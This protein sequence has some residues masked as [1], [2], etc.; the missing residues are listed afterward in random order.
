M[1]PADTAVNARVLQT[2]GFFFADSCTTRIEG[3]DLSDQDVAITLIAAKPTDAILNG[4]YLAT[5][6]PVLAYYRKKGRDDDHNHAVGST[7]INMTLLGVVGSK[8]A[9]ASL[10]ESEQSTIC[11][12]IRGCADGI[13]IICPNYFLIVRSTAPHQAFRD[14]IPTEPTGGW[15][16]VLDAVDQPQAAA[17]RFKAIIGNHRNHAVCL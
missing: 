12:F 13:T 11:N 3:D 1:K 14:L 10:S 6:P 8:R 16:G 4:D 15:E 7:A 9:M 2:P 5:Q 17:K